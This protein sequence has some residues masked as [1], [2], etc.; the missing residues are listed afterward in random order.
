MNTAIFKLSDLKFLYCN[1]ESDE[2]RE[3][4]AKLIEEKRQ[5]LYGDRKKSILNIDK[6]FD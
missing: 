1:A 3:E 5:E 6:P 2:K 4:L